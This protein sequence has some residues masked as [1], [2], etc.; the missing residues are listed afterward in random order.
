M[1]EVWVT[2][3]GVATKINFIMYIYTYTRLKLFNLISFKLCYR[4]N[5]KIKYP[6]S[7]MVHNYGIYSRCKSEMF[8]NSSFN[9]IL[10]HSDRRKQNILYS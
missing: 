3:I 8:T 7:L 5:E 1:I 9:L 6:K 10:I 2:I 4:L